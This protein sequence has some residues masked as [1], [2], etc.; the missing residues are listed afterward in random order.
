M[1]TWLKNKNALAWVLMTCAG[2]IHVVDEAA[3]GFLSFYNPLVR[4]LRESLG[5]WP[6]PTFST[7][8]WL[9]GLIVAIIISFLLTPVVARGGRFMRVVM[10]VIGVVMVLNGL[11]HMLGSV[12]FGYLL[13]GFWSSPLLLATS[14]FVVVR[15]F[16]RAGWASWQN[17]SIS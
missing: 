11:A 15:G 8:V 6:M 12:Y 7:E 16:G 9:I 10:T 5:F 1:I 2:A 4:D 17:N 13:P 3:H 14:V